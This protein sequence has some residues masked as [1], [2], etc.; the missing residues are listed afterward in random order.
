LK[1]LLL[2]HVHIFLFTLE[3]LLKVYFASVRSKLEYI[4]HAS[5]SVTITDS[6]KLQRMYKFASLS[7]SRFF[8]DV[9]PSFPTALQLRVSFG[10]LN[11]LPPFFSTSGADCLVSEQNSFY[12]VKFLA[13][14]P[15][16]NLEDQGVPLCLAPTP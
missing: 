5:N 12:C 11:N 4:S 1:E 3:R 13:S 9:L 15:T 14:S 16:P 2:L 7:H 6:S 8:Q 10:L